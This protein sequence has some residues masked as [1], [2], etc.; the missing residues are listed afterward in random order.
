MTN[1]FKNK[2]GRP[3]NPEQVTD[4]ATCLYAIGFEL[5]KPPSRRDAKRLRDL[6]SLRRSFEKIADREAQAER[7]RIKEQELDLRRSE[8][9]VRKAEAEAVLAGAK[10]RERTRRKPAP[11]PIA[12]EPE[13]VPAVYDEILRQVREYG[14]Q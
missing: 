12:P 9:P 7:L 8:L 4:L 10:R 2:G 11:K 6:H 1:E 5:A 3:R 13:P 14:A